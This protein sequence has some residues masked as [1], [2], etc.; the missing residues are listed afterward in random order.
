[1]CKGIKTYDE[2][3]TDYKKAKDNLII[4]IVTPLLNLVTEVCNA[5]A[6]TLTAILP[7]VAYFLDSN[8]LAQ[9]VNNLLAPITSKKGIIGQLA[10]YDIDIDAIIKQLAGKSLG[11]IIT[12]AIGINVNLTFNLS[13]LNSCNIQ[14]IIMPLIAKILADKNIN[15]KLPDISFSEL[16]ALGTITTVN[17]KAKNDEG[18]YETRQV[19]AEKGKVLIAVLRYVA[20]VLIK[21]STEIGKLV[22]NID[23]IKKNSTLKNIIDCVFS[24]IKSASKDDIVRAIFYL[25]AQTGTLGVAEDAF[26]DYSGF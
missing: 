16:A 3:I 22:S 15:I 17:S 25:L 2:Y 7:N 14:D 6:K 5:P 12:D 23:A 9:V 4:D 20:D 10:N 18:K 19:V 8:G 11:D 13:D 26:F 21:N 1:M 24:S